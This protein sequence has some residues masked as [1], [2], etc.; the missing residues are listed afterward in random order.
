MFNKDEEEFHENQ[1]KILGL[2][3]KKPYQQKELAEAIGMSGAG[4][5]YHVNILEKRKLIKRKTIATVGNVSLKE[6][7]IHPNAIQRVRLLT[8]VELSSYTLFSGMGKDFKDWE[9]STIPVTVKNLL[10]KEGYKI[11]RIVAFITEESN[12]ENAKKLV[13]IDRTIE[14][15]YFDYRNES[16]EIFLNLETIIQ[17]EMRNA[18]IILDLTPLTK[19]LTIKLLELSTKYHIPSL[20]LGKNDKG[21]NYL[22]WILI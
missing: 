17:G 18:N 3:L 19:L 21:D 10:E 5:L 16:S 13:K 11:S 2:L 22:L 8:G 20:Y 6:I 4:L 7:S 12:I 15:P 9:P 1:L 14:Y